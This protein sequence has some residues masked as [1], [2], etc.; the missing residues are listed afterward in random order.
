MPYDRLVS[1]TAGVGYLLVFCVALCLA[2]TALTFK[3]C[4]NQ[5]S[6]EPFTISDCP[7]G[8]VISI[9]WTEVGF[10]TWYRGHYV[11]HENSRCSE[12]DLWCPRYTEHPDIEACNGQR[13][14]NFT[15]V[16]LRYPQGGDQRLCRHYK[17]ANFIKIKYRCVDGIATLLYSHIRLRN[18][19]EIVPNFPGVTRYRPQSSPRKAR[20][21]KGKL[22]NCNCNNLKFLS[23]LYWRQNR[24]FA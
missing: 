7:A 17:H 15:T 20:M 6:N 10:T 1:A 12:G 9:R 24:G 4:R 23:V 13:G 14:C 2:V 21:A 19:V 5:S 8:Q 18:M 16:V 22:C 3:E 11:Y